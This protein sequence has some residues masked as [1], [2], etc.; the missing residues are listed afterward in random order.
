MLVKRACIPRVPYTC[1]GDWWTSCAR[2]IVGCSESIG[3]ELEAI[4]CRGCYD[5]ALTWSDY[6]ALMHGSFE[7]SRLYGYFLSVLLVCTKQRGLGWCRK[8][9][10]ELIKAARRGLESHLCHRDFHF[11]SARSRCACMD[12]IFRKMQCAVTSELVMGQFFEGLLM[13]SFVCTQTQILWPRH[14]L[15]DVRL[16]VHMAHHARLGRLS[17]LYLL[18]SD[19]LNEIIS[20][21][22]AMSG[23][24]PQSPG[25][26]QHGDV[27]AHSP[28]PCGVRAAEA[29]PETA[30]AREEALEAFWRAQLPVAL[31]VQIMEAAE[32]TAT[33]LLA[34]P[35]WEA[36]E[37]AEAAEAT[38][39]HVA[40][41]GI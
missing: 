40:R 13:S 1:A 21:S 11:C 36:A 26:A 28:G 22:G 2:V 25:A 32:A 39:A 10:R 37:A 12:V 19:T 20:M 5:S 31:R 30:E 17:L 41:C 35:D 8:K 24:E 27:P 33:G 3:R 4:R 38:P 15:R 29:W 23:I 14:T 18:D 16:A 7:A 6:D 34:L 9:A